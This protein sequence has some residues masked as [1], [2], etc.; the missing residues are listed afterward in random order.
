MYN[1]NKLVIL[2]GEQEI[3]KLTAHFVKQEEENFALFSYVNE[4]NDELDSLQARMV[5]LT[6]AIEDVQV[7][8]ENRGVEQTKTLEKLKTELE[9][10]TADADAAEESL[11]QVKSLIDISV[12]TQNP[13]KRHPRLKGQFV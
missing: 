2:A 3:D 1:I 10:Q 8:N 13:S 9:G 4:L 12:N 7:V 6:A 5:Q 11:T